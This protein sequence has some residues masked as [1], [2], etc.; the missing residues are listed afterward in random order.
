MVLISK[1]KYLEILIVTHITTTRSFIQYTCL[2]FVM[3][4]LVSHTSRLDGQISKEIELCRHKDILLK[5][6]FVFFRMIT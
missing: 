5:Y 6:H 1:W 3:R 2:L 4:I